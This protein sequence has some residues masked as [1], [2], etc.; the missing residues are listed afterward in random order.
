[1]IHISQVCKLENV[2]HS[3]NKLEPPLPDSTTDPR[4]FGWWSL[5]IWLQNHSFKLSFCCRFSAAHSRLFHW[6]HN[7][8]FECGTRV[9]EHLFTAD[10][11]QLIWGYLVGGNTWFFIFCHWGT[12]VSNHPFL[13]NSA[14]DLT[15]LV[16]SCWIFTMLGSST[17]FISC[18]MYLK[19]KQ[20]QL[21]HTQVLQ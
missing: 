9:S 7:W 6:W 16:S 8:F 20:M 4:L 1:M 18:R 2:S 21:H 11:Q 14:V 17:R 5:I 3:C 12:R 10:F 19:H 15:L 13:L